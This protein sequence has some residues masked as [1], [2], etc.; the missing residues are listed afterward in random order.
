VGAGDPPS[1]I[2]I[3]GVPV[4]GAKEFVY[5]GSKLSSNGYCR[6]D[7]LCRIGLACSV[8]NS[9]RMVWK[10]SCLSINTKHLY[11]ALVMS[12]LLYGAEAWTLFVADMNTLEAFHLSCQRQILD[13][14]CLAYISN[15]EVL[16]R[17]GLST[18]GDIL[19]HRRLSPFGHVESLNSGVPAHDALRLMVDTCEGRKAMVSWRRPP[20]RPHINLSNM[21]FNE[22]CVVRAFFTLLNGDI[23]SAV[24]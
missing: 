17:S 15:A 23:T 19:R 4:E 13:I 14:R 6:P 20:G 24:H 7:E 5:L 22:N 16:Q 9:L 21:S 2:L 3:D 18:I 11:Q 10:W 12:V 8:M 1:T